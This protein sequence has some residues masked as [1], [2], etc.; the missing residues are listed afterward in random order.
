MKNA[1]IVSPSTPNWGWR[2]WVIVVVGITTIG[3]VGYKAFDSSDESTKPTPTPTTISQQ[4]AGEA[5]PEEK[6]RQ[7]ILG[8]IGPLLDK[9]SLRTLMAS[10]GDSALK[11]SSVACLM[12]FLTSLSI[13]LPTRKN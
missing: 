4:P 3:F 9:D 11:F 6:R 7:E 5:T 12:G 1:T 10:T 2:R 8:I 13:Y